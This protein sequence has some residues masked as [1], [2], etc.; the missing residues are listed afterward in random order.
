MQKNIRNKYGMISGIYGIISN[1]IIGLLK[2]V[3]GV[4]SNS[5]S[6]IVD[7]FNNL[8]DMTSSVLTLIAFSLTGKK[9]DKEHP[10]GH[11]RY[12]YVFSLIISI[13][14]LLT[15]LLFMYK[16]ILKIIHSEPLDISMIT[17][18]ILVVSILIKLSQ[19]FVYIHYYKKTKSKTLK[20]SAMD[21]RNDCIIT[22]SILISMIIMQIFNINIDGIVSLFISMF[23]IYSSFNMVLDS[24]HTLVGIT[25]SKS[26]VNN[27]KKKI[28][29]HKEVLGIHDLIIHNYGVDCNYISVHIELDSK[30]SLIKAHEIMDDIENE[31]KDNLGFDITIHV[32]PV[33][34]DD[35]NAQK[36]KKEV[37]S[38]LKKLDKDI[39]IHD[40][41]VVKRSDH[42]K[43]LFDAVIPFEYDYTYQDLCDYLY[44][45]IDNNNR[46]RIEIDR[47]YV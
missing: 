39:E 24:M 8:F 29:A 37:L 35:T 15:G 9:A 28:S 38:T 46:Y 40:F 30:L 16:S 32:D 44:K 31:I 27:I 26:L 25:P 21:T 41:R 7:A 18:I 6:I 1:L 47:P 33:D 11:A 22:I 19:A 36:I 10:Y 2:L 3:I 17:Y 43:V 20:I 34:V 45:N 13:I 14:M 5:M 4:I 23:I 12:E 42:Y